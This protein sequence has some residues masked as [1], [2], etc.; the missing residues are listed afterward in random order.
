M[1]LMHNFYRKG[2]LLPDK[3]QMEGK[4]GVKKNKDIKFKGGMVFAP[5]PGL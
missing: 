3:Y 1:L 4:K 5:I 2:Y